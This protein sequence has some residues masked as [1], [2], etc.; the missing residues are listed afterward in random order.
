MNRY[1]IR[2]QDD[3]GLCGIV[4]DRRVKAQHDRAHARVWVAEADKAGRRLAHGLEASVG[5]DPLADPSLVLVV[6]TMDGAEV[7]REAILEVGEPDPST[8]VMPED[9]TSSG[10]Q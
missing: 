7:S 10:E 8:V 5:Y 6:L 3:Q 2:N 1:E 4:T 9:E